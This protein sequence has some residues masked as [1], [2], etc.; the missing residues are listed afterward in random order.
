MAKRQRKVT[1]PLDVKLL[2][3]MFDVM[4]VI[5]EQTAVLERHDRELVA[6]RASRPKRRRR[7]VAVP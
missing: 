3:V 7:P 4:E 1:L 2:L 5:K 6:L